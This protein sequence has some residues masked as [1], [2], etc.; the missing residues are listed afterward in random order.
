[1]I[2][3][4]YRS[5][6][7]TVIVFVN[8]AI[9]MIVELLASRAL[10][11]YFG[12]STL[13]WTSII[14][15]LLGALSIGYWLGGRI[16][17]NKKDLGLSQLGTVL[18]IA[19][20]VLF[21]SNVMK[22]PMLSFIVQITRDVKIG[23]IVGST[24]LFGLPII[25]MGIVSPFCLAVGL[26]TQ[27]KDK[28]GEFIGRI[29]SVGTIGS[30][31]GT[32]LGGF[33]LISF[34]GTTTLLICC[35]VVLILMG[36]SVG[37][38]F[39]KIMSISLVI[40]IITIS[41]FQ[42]SSIPYVLK[43]LDTLYGRVWIQDVPVVND[44][45]RILRIN[46]EYSSGIFL[47]S[48]KYAFEYT[49]VVDHLLEIKPTTQEALLLGGGAYVM[50]RE[51]HNKFPEIN[52]DIVEIDEK[53]LGIGEEYFEYVQPQNHSIFSEDARTFLNE[54]REKKYDIV[55]I[56]VYKSQFTIPFHLVTREAVSK[57]SSV[58]KDDGVVVMN[59]IAAEDLD[60][61]G[62]LSSI[63]K[64]FQ[65]DFPYIAI[66]RIGNEKNIGKVS[67][68]LLFAMTNAEAQSRIV[69]LSKKNTFF[70]GLKSFTPSKEAIVFTDDFAPVDRF[71]T[72]LVESL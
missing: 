38:P 32:F 4:G 45:M 48:D 49:Q 27:D 26:Q 54:G 21:I 28:S 55:F 12:T 30:I 53:L 60:G 3:N 43:D 19:G 6:I 5:R 63:A 18:I 51:I 47:K 64:T 41:L 22:E 44:I 58:I 23:S 16:V 34:F 59:I 9:I 50:P 14:A 31:V 65:E 33:L 46:S 20:V 36:I 29:Y 7:L 10:A 57:V 39:P 61:T 37:T 62:F 42:K 11:P 1:M 8:G 2:S 66:M 24:V 69:E 35:S 13:I 56:D 71:A 72:Y 52:L 25:L 17:Q 15:I 68:Y 40:G 70:S 67:N